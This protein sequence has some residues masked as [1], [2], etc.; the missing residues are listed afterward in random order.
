MCPEATIKAGFFTHAEGVAMKGQT[1]NLSD[2]EY[3]RG[4]EAGAFE[5]APIHTDALEAA[6]GENDGGASVGENA[7]E[8]AEPPGDAD[9]EVGEE[10]PESGPLAPDSPNPPSVG[11]PTNVEAFEEA[12]QGESAKNVDDLKG[13]AL[14][15]AVADAGID[16]SKGG[17]LSDGS[18]SAD[19]KRAA[20]KNRA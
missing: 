19:E 16:A 7:P 9:V 17:S 13:E 4:K 18:L 3:E 20:L 2:E 8:G 15:K 10:D 11:G 6:F 12:I 5:D 14:D 1:V